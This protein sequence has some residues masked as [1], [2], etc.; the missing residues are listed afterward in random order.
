M[1]E[2]MEWRL[3]LGVHKTATT[4]L[5][6]TLYRQR[7]TLAAAGISVI[8]RTASRDL[9]LGRTLCGIGWRGLLP[10]ATRRNMSTAALDRLGC[11]GPVVVWSE[12]NLI[13]RPEE[14]LSVPMF[15]RLEK[16][17]RNLAVA[18]RGARHRLF[19]SV[20]NP[21]V[22]LPSIYAQSLRTG[23]PRVAFDD[24][25]PHWLASPPRWFDLSA[26][27]TAVFMDAR[28]TVWP[29][30]SYTR[31]PEPILQRLAGSDLVRD[32]D[33]PPPAGTRRPSARAVAAL[34]ALPRGLRGSAWRTRADEILSDDRGELPF[35]PLTEGQRALLSDAYRAD[36]SAMQESGVEIMA[37]VG[38]GRGA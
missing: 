2:P 27:I 3:H 25:L 12:E 8:P 5:Q 15:P 1:T 35:D 7:A 20:R 13:G 11:A 6:D 37:G 21:A 31:D 38:P 10:V 28:L 17:L 18:T 33:L 23:P 30:E 36:L 24:L 16:R 4:H 34:E 19:L 22:V 32:L 9:S 26:R 29:M 14:M